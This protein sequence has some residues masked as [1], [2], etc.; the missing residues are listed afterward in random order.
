M[1]TEPS[2]HKHRLKRLAALLALIAISIGA[3]MVA[4]V[5]TRQE[6]SPGSAK[7]SAP[8]SMPELVGTTAENSVAPAADP[9]P[10]VATSSEHRS[11]AAN[12]WQPQ[13]GSFERLVQDA[14][15]GDDE[16]G[17]RLLIEALRCSVQ[18]GRLG[19]VATAIER[20]AVEGDN[21]FALDF[22]ARATEEAEARRTLC[23]AAPG[24]DALTR[25]DGVRERL[26]GLHI[27]ARVI[28]AMTLPDGR[29]MRLHADQPENHVGLAGTGEEILPEFIAEH[30]LRFLAEGLQRGDSL[31]L[32]GLLIV[33]APGILPQASFNGRFFALPHPR[34][35]A[36]HALTWRALWGD[37]GLVG[38]GVP[39]LLA[40]TLDEMTPDAR[41]RLE[42]EVA[43]EVARWHTVNGDTSP[44][45]PARDR[46]PAAVCRSP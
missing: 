44:R 33:H 12:A 30:G 23:D 13:D 35:F 21:P 41:Q 8:R 42:A 14:L 45:L 10:S 46:H 39:E 32:E 15:A 6:S 19:Q 29:I 31:A 24:P 36:L 20:M 40:T 28:M 4:R 26:L 2:A 5:P 1:S 3:L 17:C 43:T 7:P 37:A 22:V 38:T 16:A 34:R 18:R 25:R 11:V 9:E 27:R